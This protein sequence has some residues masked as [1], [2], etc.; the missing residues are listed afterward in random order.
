[1]HSGIAFAILINAAKIL[2]LAT[3]WVGQGLLE[4][5]DGAKVARDP[6]KER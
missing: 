2:D 4:C 6:C 5:G 1:L 3:L